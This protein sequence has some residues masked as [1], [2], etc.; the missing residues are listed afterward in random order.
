MMMAQR[1]GLSGRRGA[2][3]PTAAGVIRPRVTFGALVSNRKRC[4]FLCR[5]LHCIH[6]S[7]S[8]ASGSGV[9]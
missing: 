9:R 4:A 5:P 3:P 8:R 6:L 1:I 2:I 7:V